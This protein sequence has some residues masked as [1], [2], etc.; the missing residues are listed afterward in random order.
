VI[1][2]ELLKYTFFRGRIALY[3]ILRSLEID[4]EDTV[5]TQGFTC[6][7]VP[8]AIMAA[9]ARPIYID[10]EADGV[11]MSAKDLEIKIEKSTKAVIVQHT[12]GIPANMEEIG[13]IASKYSVPIIED[14][15]HSLNSELQ[16]QPVGS[17]GCAAFYSFE[18]GKPIIIGI[19]GAAIINSRS[20]EEKVASIYNDL[21][22]PEKLR[23]WR[24][25]VQNMVFRLLY[26]PQFY[27]SIRK[28]FHRF[29]RYGLAEGNYNQVSFGSPPSDFGLRMS[30]YH[31]KAL[32]K[33]LV[34]LSR[35]SEERRKNCSMY[36]NGISTP[37]ACHITVP[38]ETTVV[39]NRFPLILKNEKRGTKEEVLRAAQAARIELSDWFSSP[40]HPLRGKELEKVFYLKGSCPNA[41]S[42]CGQIVTLPTQGKISR[43]YIDRTIEFINNL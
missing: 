16:N 30:E 18:W 43:R 1:E 3:T 36:R 9:G 6:L 31:K 42:L 13:K 11:N 24:L 41:E 37:K 8:E 17:Y 27:W 32:K 29:V 26:R 19:G 15:C 38:Q 4:E 14:C 34:D 35:L 28:L 2:S 12:Y 10:T 5:A 23:I 22:Y 20:F 7:A 40:V 33:K 21:Q 39:Y 25:R